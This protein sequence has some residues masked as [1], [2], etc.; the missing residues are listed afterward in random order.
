LENRAE[1]DGDML[2]ENL[3]FGTPDQVI[4]K[5][6][7]YEALGVD[8]FMYY[9]SLGLGHAEQKRSLQLFCDEVMPAFA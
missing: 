8:N 2:T 1:Y 7:K 4:A 5:L 3:V 9:A 6:R